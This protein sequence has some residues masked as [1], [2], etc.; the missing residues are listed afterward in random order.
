MKPCVERDLIARATNYKSEDST[1]KAACQLAADIFRQ[2]FR[3]IPLDRES[4]YR[5]I[6]RLLDGSTAEIEKTRLLIAE[7]VIEIAKDAKSPELLVTRRSEETLEIAKDTKSPELLVTRRSKETLEDRIVQFGYPIWKCII[8]LLEYAPAQEMEQKTEQTVTKWLYRAGQ[9]S[10]QIPLGLQQLVTHKMPPSSK[11]GDMIE[12]HCK[13][14][15][16]YKQLISEELTALKDHCY[17]V[18]LFKNPSDIKRH[19]FNAAEKLLHFLAGGEELILSDAEVE[20][21][22]DISWYNDKPSRLKVIADAIDDNMLPTAYKER[23]QEKLEARLP[24]HQ[25]P[26]MY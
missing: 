2:T 23:R 8:E 17:L 26:C 12:M 9:F 10:G 7:C 1:P 14:L 22:I 3:V 20:A 18:R 16:T 11:R 15:R 24:L 5:K 13:Q 25:Q 6:H 21:L 19:K 4:V